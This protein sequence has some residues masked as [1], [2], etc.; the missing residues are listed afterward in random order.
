MKCPKIYSRLPGGRL[1]ANKKPL[2][3]LLSYVRW[4]MPWFA[5]KLKMTSYFF[6]TKTKIS[7]CWTA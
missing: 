7:I 4:W 2:D 3:D 1:H 5:L 6:G